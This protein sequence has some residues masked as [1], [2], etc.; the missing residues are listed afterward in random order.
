NG[1][2]HSGRKRNERRG[3]C[4]R[5]H[6]RSRAAMNHAPADARAADDHPERLDSDELGRAHALA[7]MAQY[8][9]ALPPAGRD[10]S[11][12]NSGMLRLIDRMPW[13]VLLAR[14]KKE[15]SI[16]GSSTHSPT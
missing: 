14:Q 4:Q 3:G 1:A 7:R 8:R 5:P 13:A 12:T 2:A 16:E 15:Q 11:A 10:F 6:A 9:R